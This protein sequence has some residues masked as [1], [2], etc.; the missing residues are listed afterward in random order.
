MRVLGW[1]LVLCLCVGCQQTGPVVDAAPPVKAASALAEQG[2]PVKPLPAGVHRGACLAHNWQDGGDK[3]YGTAASLQSK[4]ELKALG[5]DW[6]SLTPFGW[7]RDLKAR[8]VQ[9]NR[10][11]MEAGE[12][13]A[14]M[15]EE[16]KQAHALGLKVILKPHIWV[17]HSEWQGHIQPEG[18][19]G[20]DAWFASY[21]DFILHY[22]RMAEEHQLEALV[23]GLE[24]A[25][26]SW[27]QR[28]HWVKLIDQIRAVYKGKLI[29]AANWNEAEGVTFW[30]K[31]DWIGVQFFP[32]LTERLDPSYDELAASIDKQLD[33][34]GQLHKKYNKPV[35]LT[36]YGYKSIQAAAISPHTWPEH[37]PEEAKTYQE[38]VQALAYR[39][40][41]NRVGERPYIHG[42]Y[43]W[44]WFTDVK[45]DEEGTI[46]FSPRNKRAA[47]VMKAAHAVKEASP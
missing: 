14:R 4:K 6:I 43:V 21:G 37:L 12:T 41:F 17:S 5:V 39:A 10:G 26:S 2:P 22:A 1:G 25:S 28:D 27:H 11:E 3:G 8:A 18:P 30:D 19:D 38:D 7:Q 13:D 40:L 47:L 31:V 44:K 33:I 35:V 29:Y 16:I 45:T 36:E 24:L 42:V 34:Y 23:I 32:P 9:R 46:G 20:W 15:A